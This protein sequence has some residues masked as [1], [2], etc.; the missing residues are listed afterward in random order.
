[1]LCANNNSPMQRASHLN[2][3]CYWML[4][5]IY[6]VYYQGLGKT[7]MI[8][9]SYINGNSGTAQFLIESLITLWGK[10]TNILLL[11]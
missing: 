5:H 1:M 7:N 8:C 6:I 3:S 11:H 9:H 4:F 10:S 2:Y